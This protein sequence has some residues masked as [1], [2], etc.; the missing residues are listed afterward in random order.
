MPKD[1]ESV[2]ANIHLSSTG[3]LGL[4]WCCMLSSLL[5]TGVG[6]DLGGL[7]SFEGSSDFLLESLLRTLGGEGAGKTPEIRIELSLPKLLLPFQFL[8]YLPF[9]AMM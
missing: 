5:H 3:H 7:I 8:L 2:L 9:Q 6:H 4:L 1:I